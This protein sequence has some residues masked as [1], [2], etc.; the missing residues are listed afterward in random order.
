MAESG[1][2]LGVGKG[3]QIVVGLKR[4]KNEQSPTSNPEPCLEAEYLLLYDY[5]A[6]GDEEYIESESGRVVLEE[7][8]CV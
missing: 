5:G 8:N 4:R 7:S 6:V 3:G 2:L 1:R